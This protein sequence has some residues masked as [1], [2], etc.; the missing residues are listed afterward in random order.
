MKLHTKILI[1]LA[2]GI[3]AGVVVNFIAPPDGSAG[4]V[5]WLIDNVTDPVGQVFLRLLFM[6]VVPLVFA[7]LSLGV[8]NLGDLKTLGKVGAR[9]FIYFVVLTAIATTLGLFLMQIAAP[10]KSFDPAMQASLM[11]AYGS[12]TSA[13]IGRSQELSFTLMTFVD[14]IL[15]RNMLRAVVEMQMLP[16]ILLSLLFGVML[17]KMDDQVSGS[18]RRG[19]KGLE[20]FAI[21]V[22]DL[23][24]RLAPYAVPCLVFG[25]AARFGLEILKP[26]G[27]Y[28]ALVFVGYLIHLFGVYSII[29]K[30]VAKVSP[31]RF[32]SAARPVMVTAFSTSSSNA[33]LPTTIRVTE[34]EMGVSSKIAGFVLPLGA[35]TNMNG[36]A[37]YEGMT[38]LFI[39]Q[40]FGVELTLI[41]QLVVVLMTVVTAIG[42]AGVPGGSLPLIVLVLQSV[43]VPPEGIGIIL[44]VDRVLDM[45]RT[46]LNVTGD[47]TAAVYVA[48]QQGE[49]GLISVRTSGHSQ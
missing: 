33:T 5:T 14:M 29:L 38:V 16:V 11:D 15:P 43:G 36:T 47:M 13:V 48:N 12:K 17:T 30:L 24:M 44:G 20:E 9:T 4:T 49:K 8:S 1:G 39:A 31:L 40:I 27:L 32:F 3:L 21:R 23:A 19:L 45:G 35:T 18:M 25:V 26:L 34:Q 6:I 7:S 10:G 2:T 41:Q 22:V 37:L 28:V 42:T 46:V